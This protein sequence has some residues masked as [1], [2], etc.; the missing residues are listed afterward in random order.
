LVD[1]K[2]LVNVAFFSGFEQALFQLITCNLNKLNK[3]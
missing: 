2:E 1:T 3:V